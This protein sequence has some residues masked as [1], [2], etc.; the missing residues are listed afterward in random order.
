ML[1]CSNCGDNADVPGSQLLTPDGDFACSIKCKKEWE[2]KR[3]Y[4][5][6]AVIH[7]DAMMESWWRGD[8]FPGRV[9]GCT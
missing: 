7:D 3:D 4:F 2:S 9:E 5:L 8:D 1:K 6:N